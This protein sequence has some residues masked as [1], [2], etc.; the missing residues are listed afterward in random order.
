MR[1]REYWK[2]KGY[3]KDFKQHFLYLDKLMHKNGQYYLKFKEFLLICKNITLLWER[4]LILIGIGFM[5]LFIL[6]LLETS[7]I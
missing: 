2:D 3:T 7:N 4:V 6:L 5:S 1:N